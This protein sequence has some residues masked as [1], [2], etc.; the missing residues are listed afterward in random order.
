MLH[1]FMVYI[2]HRKS[3]WVL[4]DICFEE[5]WEECLN[6]YL[7]LSFLSK[8]SFATSAKFILSSIFL[9][10]CTNI[11]TCSRLFSIVDLRYVFKHFKAEKCRFFRYFWLAKEKVILQYFL[12][13]F[14]DISCNF[15]V[16]VLI[17]IVLSSL[18]ANKTRQ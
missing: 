7:R 8:N 6:V 5:F 12:L 11:R 1:S 18:S 15:L 9:W 13:L 2:F 4:T 16:M 17:T 3:T 10:T 14:R